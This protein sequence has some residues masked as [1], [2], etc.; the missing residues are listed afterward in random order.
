MHTVAHPEGAHA[1]LL[2]LIATRCRATAALAL[3]LQESPATMQPRL[4][5]LF[6]QLLWMSAAFPLVGCG[7]STTLSPPQDSGAADVSAPNDQGVAPDRGLPADVGSPHDTPTVDAGD[8]C[9]PVELTNSTCEY[10][11]RFPCGVPPEYLRDGSN[12]V[13]HPLCRAH[14][15]FGSAT[16]GC[17]LERTNPDGSAEASC[18][19]CA[20]GRRTE[21]YIPARAPT[22]E[23]AT[24]RFFAR[25]AELEAASVVSFR[26][27]ADELTAHGAPD[28]LVARARSAA[29]DERRHTRLMGDLARRYGATPPRPT[30]RRRGVRPLREVAVENAT[31]GCVRETFGALLA[32]W[33]SSHA[34]DAEIA[35]AMERIADDETRHAE[36]AWAIAAWLDTVLDE[37][38]RG[39]VREA[40]DGAVRELLREL[41]GETPAELVTIAGM[42]PTAESTRMARHLAASLW[43]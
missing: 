39:A 11:V 31:E 23:T 43:S 13:D 25:V 1:R 41:A 19:I 17:S 21:G 4:K 28:A 32:T 6:Q 20:V 2:C 15:S 24:G 34:G 36:L 37:P 22:G 3:A 16:A 29:R 7:A 14:C 33:Q 42:A 40:R 8:R 26:T 35:R 10:R 9:A 5:D 30:V 18:T 27:L 12:E 38:A